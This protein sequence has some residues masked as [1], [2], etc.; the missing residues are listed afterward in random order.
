MSTTIANI[1]W[2]FVSGSVNTKIEYK[3][4]TDSIWIVP[5]SPGNPTTN[6]FYPIEIENNVT[7]DVRLTTYGTRC[8]PKST[9][10]QIINPGADC[11]PATYTLSVDGTYCYKYIDVA[12][13]APTG[14][15]N[16][17]AS[18]STEY[19]PYGTVIYA[20]G[21]N[22]GG[23]G[24]FTLINT[25][26][27]FWINNPI[28]TVNGPNNRTAL[29]SS[30]TL[31]NQDIGFSICVTLP[32]SGT[33]YVGCM[34]D[35]YIKI[36]LDGVPIMTMDPVAMANYF[37]ANGYPG[38]STLVTFR[39]WHVYPVAMTAGNHIIEMVGHNDS[40]IAGM[41][42]E[43]YN[44]TSTE[45]QAATSY[46]SL[47][48]KLIFSTKDYVGQPIQIGTG[49]IGYTC[50]SGYALVLCDG[51]AYCRQTLTTPTISC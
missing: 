20:P 44:A 19:G 40:S 50:P 42:A 4:S 34:A 13:T 5:T 41:G 48:S 38:V 24:P 33:Y 11:C 9:T 49:G 37:E 45:I 22:I 15:E 12:A 47:G 46:A 39:F 8:S 43:V 30:T 26:N 21:Y 16:A 23:Y 31:S 7:Y 3:R 36:R 6:N 28:N 1:G 27:S 35:N 25:S 32:T 14:S 2:P 17:F 51:P 29:W 10:L 18:P